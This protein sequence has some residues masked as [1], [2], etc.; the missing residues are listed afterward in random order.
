MLPRCIGGRWCFPH[1]NAHESL[2]QKGFC[3]EVGKIW[4]CQD[5]NSKDRTWDFRAVFFS[6]P[7]RVDIAAHRYTIKQFKV[8]PLASPPVICLPPMKWQALLH[9]ILSPNEKAGEP[10]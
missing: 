2:I 7:A 1:F 5:M 4:C 8:G 10:I 9:Q 3:G 6:Y